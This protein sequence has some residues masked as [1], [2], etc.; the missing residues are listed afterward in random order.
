VSSATVAGAG[1]Q[2]GSWEDRRITADALVPGHQSQDLGATLAAFH[3]FQVVSWPLLDEAVRALDV[4]RHRRVDVCGQEVIVQW[5]PGRRASTT[6]HVD[7]ASLRQRRCFLCE[8]N[9]PPE[10]RALFFGKQLV[11]LCNPAPLARRHLVIAHRDHE[12]QA[13]STCLSDLV[14]FAAAAGP[15][16]LVLYNGPRAGASAPHHLHLQALLAGQLPVERLLRDGLDRG[17]IPGAEPLVDGHELCAWSLPLGRPGAGASPPRA[18]WAF[19]GE[20]AAVATGLAAALQTLQ[21]GRSNAEEPP[22]NVIVFAHRDACAAVLFPRAAHRPACF[23]AEDPERLLVSPGAVDVA[24]LVITV[25]EEDFDRLDERLLAGIFGETCLAPDALA[26]LSL[27]LAEKLAARTG[28]HP[29][30]QP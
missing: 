13:L 8:A 16:W 1:H 21:E 15:D 17:A 25:R 23:F 2:P 12:P 19:A 20:A 14:A 10:E 18:T 30:P 29:K 3:A 4:V 24:G 28:T 6:A 26:P 27:R 7:P 11:V 9:L 22:L 5:N